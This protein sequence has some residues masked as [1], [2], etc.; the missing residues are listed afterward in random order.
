MKKRRAFYSILIPAGA[1]KPPGK[2]NTATFWRPWAAKRRKN[3]FGRRLEKHE[4]LGN[5]GNIWEKLKI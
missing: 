3:R 4:H 2:F 5:F 1:K